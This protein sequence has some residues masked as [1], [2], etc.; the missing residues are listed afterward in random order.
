MDDFTWF[1]TSEWGRDK[2]LREKLEEQSAYTSQLL[3]SH[4]SSSNE[5]RKKLNSLEGDL[6]SRLNALSSAF[7]AYVELD[8]VRQELAAF[9]SHAQARR[10]AREDLA[11]VVAGGEPPVRDDIEGYWLVPGVA[12]LRPDGTLDAELAATASGR[13]ELAARRFW[14]VARA[15]MGKG[16]E[17]LDEL[18]ALMAPSDAPEGAT[19]D[20]LQV[21]LWAGTLRGAFGPDALERLHEV[22][23]P[24]LGAST[25]EMWQEWAAG[26]AQAR[27][28][29]PGSNRSA[30]ETRTIE[31]VG[32]QL[33]SVIEPATPSSDDN[34]WRMIWQAPTN[35]ADDATAPSS[36]PVDAGEA[37]AS[38]RE[39]LLR[40]AEHIIAE[41]AAGER[42][43]LARAK[44]LRAELADPLGAAGAA[45]EAAEEPSTLP[46]SPSR[47]ADQVRQLA[48]DENASVRDRR[49]IWA[50]LA[51]YLRDWL[52]AQAALP[53]P[54]KTVTRSSY[55]S[56]LQVNAAGPLDTK[57]LEL[58]RNATIQAWSPPV[59]G[60]QGRIIQ[61]GSIVLGVLGLVLVVVTG[62]PGWWAMLVAGAAGTWLGG[63][64]H[65]T[66]REVLD[67]KE[68][69]R[70]RF[71]ESIESARTS[72]QRADNEALRA[73]EARTEAARRAL[74]LLPD[75]HVDTPALEA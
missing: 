21:M 33:A 9:P 44:E 43:L 16:P 54:D 26:Q 4:Y 11:S 7:T 20:P 71:D 17:L 60:A 73:H 46:A 75:D 14:L 69:A 51:P 22:I 41:G 5:L 65:R 59:L 72:A 42:A 39:M 8:A 48:V 50:W 67:N 3:S 19:W 58:A 27:L 13:D 36:S 1:W 64:L 23:E 62:Q 40:V 24:A 49:T 56:K 53:A 47:V 52:T 29:R 32:T 66:Y 38:T 68:R 37:W 55:D 10:Q 30:G 61:I 57:A 2:F 6:S 70:S 45:S 63:G 18:V 31:W 74:S 25:P 15:A 35:S 12:A 34:S 28:D